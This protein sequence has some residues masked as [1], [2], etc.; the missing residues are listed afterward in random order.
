MITRSNTGFALL[1]H[2]ADMGFM[3]WAPELKGLFEVSAAALTAILVNPDAVDSIRFKQ[4]CVLVA[5]DIE[6]RGVV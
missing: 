6:L 2:P 3:T 5:E 4:E 1:D